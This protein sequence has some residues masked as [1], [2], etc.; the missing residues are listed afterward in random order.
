VLGY[1]FANCVRIT[2]R[3]VADAHGVI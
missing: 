2:Q 3:E 1:P